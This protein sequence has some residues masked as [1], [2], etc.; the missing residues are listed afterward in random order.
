MAVFP[1]P[2]VVLTGVA[3][4]PT[5][6][7]EFVGTFGAGTVTPPLDGTSPFAAIAV[8]IKGRLVLSL[9]LDPSWILLVANDRYKITV[10]EPVFCYVQVF[11]I[12]KPRDP[13]LDYTDNGGGR[14]ARPVARRVRVYVYTRSGS[15]NYGDDT[16]AL[17]GFDSTL[18]STAADP[19]QGGQFLAEE[20][21]FAAFDDFLPQTN[22]GT[23]LTL[24]PLHP[25]DA[26][27]EPQRKPED[28]EGL[29]RSCLDFEA[30]YL[31]AQDPTEP[32]LVG[33]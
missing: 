32:Q 19:S 5:T 2:S 14:R 4:G 31:V 24:G 25:L 20:R 27:E 23:P 26:S 12:E 28:G 33:G 16:V 17:C 10:T 8:A 18:V 7:T 21:V 30:V 22:D 29:L 11:G 1:D 15:D 6:G 3:Y 13:A 9:G